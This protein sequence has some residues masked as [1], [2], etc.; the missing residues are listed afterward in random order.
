MPRSKGNTLQYATNPE[1]EVRERWENRHGVFP[2]GNSR[3][4]TVPSDCEVG[5]G[6]QLWAGQR[7]GRTVHLTVV[8]ASLTQEEEQAART[9]ALKHS[10]AET[11]VPRNNGEIRPHDPEKIV[12]ISSDCD[13]DLFG[14]ESRP[15]L[16]IGEMNDTIAYLKYVPQST[17][18]AVR[19]DGADLD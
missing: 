8:M 19:L 5:T 2:Q 12:T 15:F 11:E 7:N 1:Q 9:A 10:P 14:I 6:V 4:I 17:L 18:S 3:V 16:F 13:S